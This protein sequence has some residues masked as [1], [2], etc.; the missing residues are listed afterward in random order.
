[1]FTVPDISQSLASNSGTLRLTDVRITK[2]QPP[3]AYQMSAAPPNQV[4]LTLINMAV[5]AIGNMDGSVNIIAPLEL[6]GE[7]EVEAEDVD[8][9]LNSALEKTSDG[10]PHLRILQCTGRIGKI[11]VVNHNGGVAGAGV[12]IFQ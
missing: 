10:L 7:L 8:I 9:I 3:K 4:R 11:R 5:T 1:M 12:D 6:Q 2:F